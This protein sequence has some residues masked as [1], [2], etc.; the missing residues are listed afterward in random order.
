MDNNLPVSR[1]KAGRFVKGQSGNPK[2]AKPQDRNLRLIAQ[3]Y[4]EA[5]MLTLL[6]VMQN[7]SEPGAAR[8]TAA[9]AILD[10]G[11]GKATQHIEAEVRTSFVDAI[12]AA[13]GIPRSDVIDVV[14]CEVVTRPG[15]FHS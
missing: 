7:E 15:E 10:R 5:A 11:Y 8:V 14:D 1:D 2:G 13:A 6:E 12:I 3:E 9:N 4:T